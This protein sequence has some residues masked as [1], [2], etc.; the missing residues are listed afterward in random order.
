[1]KFAFVFIVR[2]RLCGIIQLFA[3]AGATGGE[4]LVDTSVI[5]LLYCVPVATVTL[6]SFVV[7]SS[8]ITLS[9]ETV[10]VESCIIFYCGSIVKDDDTFGCLLVKSKAERLSGMRP[11]TAVPHCMISI[12][13]HAH[14]VLFS[15]QS[16]VYIPEPSPCQTSPPFNPRPH[17]PL[18]LPRPPPTA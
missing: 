2:G 11:K 8:R 4:G 6:D 18:L 14:P 10:G 17:P 16:Q 5:L 13:S 9:H 3:V 12:T 15:N 1:M 7:L